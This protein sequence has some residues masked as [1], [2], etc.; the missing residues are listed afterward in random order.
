M[1]AYLIAGG[2]EPFWIGCMASL[3]GAY[4]ALAMERKR[5]EKG[6]AKA[7]SRCEENEQDSVVACRGMGI[8]PMSPTGPRQ[9]RGMPRGGWL[10]LP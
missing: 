3:S 10:F 5:E 9:R 2:V 1:I 7:Q 6:N 8:L 4:S